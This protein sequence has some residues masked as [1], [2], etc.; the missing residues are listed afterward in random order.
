DFDLLRFSNLRIAIYHLDTG[1]IEVLGG[2]DA[3][4]NINPVWS[5][6][7][8]ALAFVSDRTGIANV[9]LYEFDDG[10]IYQ[11]TNMYTGVQGITPLSPVLTWSSLADRLAFVYYE[12]GQYSVYSVDNPR[13]LRRG[14][15][16][17]PSRLPAV[18][19]LAAEGR[20]TAPAPAPLLWTG[21]SAGPTLNPIGTGTGGAGVDS[22]T[23]GSTTAAPAGASLYRSAEGFRPSASPQPA[24]SSAVPAPLTV[25][26]L[27]DSATLALPDTTQF[28]FKPY[29]VR[30]TADYMVRPTVGYQR[31]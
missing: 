12:D 8:R 20:D 22:S 1:T 18:T 7:G 5:P 11:L 3:G 24:E 23:S 30:F 16:H 15:W 28:S 4:K 26:A 6:D 9:Y 29:R 13:S 2:M 25:R 21:T 17:G 19:L 31:D 10:L 14:P 27:L